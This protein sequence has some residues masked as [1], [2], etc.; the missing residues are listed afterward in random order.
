MVR[1]LKMFAVLNTCGRAGCVAPDEA[2]D[3][4][5]K[6]VALKERYRALRAAG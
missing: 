1:L 5:N 4:L 3:P 2:H 6:D